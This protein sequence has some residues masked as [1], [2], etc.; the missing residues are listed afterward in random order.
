M[1]VGG[2]VTHKRT[3]RSAVGSEGQD[4][5][6]FGVPWKGL[7]VVQ[8]DG[9]AAR[10]DLV[11]SLLG[12]RQ[13]LGHVVHVAEKEVGRVQQ[14]CPVRSF[15]LHLEAPQD[16][17]REALADGELFGGVRGGAPKLLVHLG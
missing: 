13:G 9:G 11:G 16:G 5:L 1:W 15:S 14:Q 17:F 10:V 3:V 2:N 6:H 8:R 4:G 12:S 7:G